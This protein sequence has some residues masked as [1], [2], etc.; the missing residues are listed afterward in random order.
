MGR[1][2]I[3]LRWKPYKSTNHVGF[4]VGKYTY[5]SHGM[6][7][8]G[9]QKS[10]GKRCLSYQKNWDI[11]IHFGVLNFHLIF[12]ETSSTVRVVIQAIQ[13]VSLWVMLK[14]HPKNRPDFWSR[15]SIKFFLEHALPRLQD[16]QFSYIYPVDNYPVLQINKP[17]TSML[18][19]CFHHVLVDKN[20]WKNPIIVGESQ[21][22]VPHLTDYALLAE[23]FPKSGEP[24]N[25][26]EKFPRGVLY[27]VVGCYKDGPFE[28]QF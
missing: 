22:K 4:H 16:T 7:I 13:F 5:Q 26:P 2:Y 17:T 23:G 1:L 3:Y 11:W 25:S 6:G 19:H 10:H 28:K 27:T 15:H 24:T 20:V 12:G 8:F 21:T 9:A 18:N 14:H